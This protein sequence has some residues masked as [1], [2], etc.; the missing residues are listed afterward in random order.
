MTSTPVRSSKLLQQVL[1]ADGVTSGVTG[2]GLVVLPARVA[3][4]IGAPSAALVAGIGA[5]L[6]LFGLGLV[7]HATRPVPGRGETILIAALNLAWVAASAVVVVAG[8]LTTLGNWAVALVG[9][10]VLGF[11][12]LELRHLPPVHAGGSLDAARA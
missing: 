2:L 4:L 6:I 11:A 9:I 5:G 8:G 7:R 10:V 1:L 3:G 12:V